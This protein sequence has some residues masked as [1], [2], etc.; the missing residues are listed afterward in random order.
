MRHVIGSGRL[1]DIGPFAGAIREEMLADS[2][3]AQA[4]SG[5]LS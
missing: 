1:R 4:L 2:G 5:L 3:V